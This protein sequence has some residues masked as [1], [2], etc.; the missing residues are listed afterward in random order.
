MKA[1]P[2]SFM[3]PFLDSLE[4][5]FEVTLE[6]IVKPIRVE[7]GQIIF[8]KFILGP[9]LQTVWQISNRNNNPI[10]ALS[11]TEIEYLDDDFVKVKFEMNISIS[12]K[13]WSGYTDLFAIAQLYNHRYLVLQENYDNSLVVICRNRTFDELLSPKIPEVHDVVHE[14]KL[15]NGLNLVC[16]EL[17]MDDIGKQK[18]YLKYACNLVDKTNPAK[19]AII[20]AYIAVQ[21][22]I[23]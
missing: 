4:G 18:A 15:Q 3:G 22:L 6:A 21:S 5:K 19:A 10:S 1:I 8:G 23:D 9:Q 13:T 12:K 14:K 20:A 11:Y 7:D 2:R 16:G 17:F